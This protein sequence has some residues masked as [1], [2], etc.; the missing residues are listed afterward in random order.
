MAEEDAVGGRHGLPADAHRAGAAKA[1]GQFAQASP[2]VRRGAAGERLLAGVERLADEQAQPGQ[3][4]L[5]LARA[6]AR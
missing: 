4:L 3:L 5:D 6:P 2:D 1:V